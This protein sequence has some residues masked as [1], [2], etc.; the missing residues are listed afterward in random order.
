MR[1]DA[2]FKATAARA[3]TDLAR[4]VAKSAHDIADRTANTKRLH[5]ITGC[6]AITALA[7]GLLGVLSYRAGDKTGYTT[8][9]ATGYAQ[10]RHEQAAAA[11][12][13]TPEGQVAY[14]FAKAGGIRDLAA[15][16]DRGHTRKG[17]TCFAKSEN[18]SVWSWRLPTAAR[19]KLRE[20]LYVLIRDPN[21]RLELT[22]GLINGQAAVRRTKT[23]K[24]S[25][26]YDSAGTTVGIDGNAC[27]LA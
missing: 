13:N 24:P 27:G 12:A 26:D 1:A 21:E 4:T 9:A 7:L 8:G 6:V 15:C 2:E 19:R 20:Q 22:T 3:R 18:G 11:W 14:A 5:W 17:D 10:A 25:R 23:L 16:S